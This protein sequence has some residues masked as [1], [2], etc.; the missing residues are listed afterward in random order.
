MFTALLPILAGL[1]TYP[2][3][4]LPQTTTQRPPNQLHRPSK[5]LSMRAQPIAPSKVHITHRRFSHKSHFQ[6]SWVK[7]S[8]SWGSLWGGVERKQ[9]RSVFPQPSCWDSKGIKV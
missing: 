6:H 8:L 3:P 1:S 9:K 7:Q 2:S 5:A 4:Q